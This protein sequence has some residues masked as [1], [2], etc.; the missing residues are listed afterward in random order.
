MFKQILHVH[1]HIKTIII[2]HSKTYTFE[3]KN[4]EAQLATKV[5]SLPQCHNFTSRALFFS[6]FF[7]PHILMEG[8]HEPNLK[9][10]LTSRTDSL[11]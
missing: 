2:S 1:A 8:Y 9:G 11:N 7:F 5:T 6:F 4:L 3:E 10:N